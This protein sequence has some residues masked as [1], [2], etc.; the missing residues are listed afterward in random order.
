MTPNGKRLFVNAVHFG[1]DNCPGATDVPEPGCYEIFSPKEIPSPGLID[2]DDLADASIIGAHY[3]PSHGV[4]FEDG[5]LAG[6]ETQKNATAV[7]SPN[8]ARNKE[9]DPKSGAAAPLSFKFDVRQDPCR[10]LHGQR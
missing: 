6:V 1:L 2:F 8:V 5:K 10:L 7:S 4:V 3:Q 9:A